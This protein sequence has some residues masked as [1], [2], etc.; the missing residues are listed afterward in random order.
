MTI[1][2][3]IKKFIRFMSN[4]KKP[5]DNKNEKS[6]AGFVRRIT[7]CSAGALSTTAIA[8][9]IALTVGIL[10]GIT[11]PLL[12]FIRCYLVIMQFADIDINE[13]DAHSNWRALIILFQWDQWKCNLCKFVKIKKQTTIKEAKLIASSS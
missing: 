2:T 3:K 9:A 10:Q 6:I 7:W 11:S 12:M 8:C 4:N 1:F 5:I 13:I